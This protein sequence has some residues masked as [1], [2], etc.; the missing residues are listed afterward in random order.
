MLNTS[1]ILETIG[2]ISRQKLDIRTITMGVSLFHCAGDDPKAVSRKVYDTICKRAENLVRVGSD[3]EREYGIPIVNTR[4]SVTPAAL[5]TAAL[6]DP[7]PVAQAMDKAA[8]AVGVNLIGGY[9]ALAQKGVTQADLRLI[10]SLPEALSATERV[11]A[12]VNVAS[13]KAGIDMDA[14]RLMGEIIKEIAEKSSGTGGAACMKLVVFA[15]A[16]EDNPFMAGAF[17][18]PGE[19]RRIAPSTWAYPARASSR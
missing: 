2:M 9:S 12:S 15:N 14:V 13:T 7:L 10:R 4:V 1:E 11:C 16:V 19:A 8:A 5:I 6:N 17:H 18:G 3:I